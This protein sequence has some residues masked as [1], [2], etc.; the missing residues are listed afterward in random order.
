MEASEPSPATVLAVFDK[1]APPGTPMTTSEIATEFDCRPETIATRLQTLVAGETLALKTVGDQEV[2]WRLQRD[3]VACSQD[4]PPTSHAT[5][6]VEPTVPIFELLDT[7]D[8]GIFI[9]DS[10]F[11]VVWCNAAIEQFFGLDRTAI[12]GADKSTLIQREVKQT[13][14]DP[15]SF[16]TTVLAT[17][18]DNTF[19]E[20]F[21][22]HVTAGEGR[23][24]RWLEHR[25]KPISSGPY[26]GGRVEL[27]YD[28]TERKQREQTAE[29]HRQQLAELN[30]INAVIQ[31]IIN[32]VI[33]QSTREE[34]EEI[35]CRRLAES[36]SY[37]FAWIGDV[38][39]YSQQVTLRTEAGVEG[40]LDDVELSADPEERGGQGPAGRAIRTKQMQVTQDVLANPDFEP[41]QEYAARYGYRS[42]AAIP[43]V[44][45]GTLYGVLGVYADRPKAFDGEV[46]T[47]IAQL[48]EIVGHAIAATERKQALMSPEITEIQFV[49]PDVLTDIDGQSTE[50]GTIGIDRTVPIGNS[51]FLEYGEID[52]DALPLLDTLVEQLLSFRGSQSCRPR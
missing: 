23:A 26:A 3:A 8:I 18:A 11:S 20:T 6:T 34:I 24:E 21:E 44:Y 51:T 17:Y 32:V 10:E 52:R 33:D 12:L 29:H 1:L 7:T 49:V 5:Q 31:G 19:V 36:E 48:G 37:E 15:D 42:M 27:Y 2:W 28:I 16:L 46:G 39:L 45:G 38:D 41:W 50:K 4:R 30:N 14:A 47:V 9:L 25:S 13:V 40:Y 43:I 35:V 22:C